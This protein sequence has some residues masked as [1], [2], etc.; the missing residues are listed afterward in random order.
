[1][2]VQ[3]PTT[4]HLELV[5]EVALTQRCNKQNNSRATAIHLN[6]LT[7]SE[8]KG[9]TAKVIRVGEGIVVVGVVPAVVLVA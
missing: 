6:Y 3:A 1:M 4:D 8:Q 9:V 7:I 5:I 2:L